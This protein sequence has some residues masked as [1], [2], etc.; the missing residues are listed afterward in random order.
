MYL[1]SSGVN[2]VSRGH[3]YSIMQSCKGDIHVE[4]LQY[5]G[6]YLLKKIHV[7]KNNKQN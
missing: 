3:L 5:L 6:N 4:K 1:G 2:V 7:Q